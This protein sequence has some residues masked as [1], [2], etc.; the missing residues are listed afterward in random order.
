LGIDESK[1]E[2]RSGGHLPENV[3]YINDQDGETLTTF[4]G[5]VKEFSYRPAAKY[6]QL[7]CPGLQSGPRPK[8]E[9]LSPAVFKSYGDVGREHEK[10]LLDNFAIALMDKQNSKGYVIAYA[11]KRAHDGEARGRAERAKDYLIKMRGLDGER[12]FATD[13]GYREEAVVELYI[14]QNGGCAPPTLPTVD[15]RDVQIT[16][17][18]K[19]K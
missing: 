15:P 1:Y 11:G 10:L 5:Q 18:R 6:A 2:K 17:P 8:C 7:L 13:G 14:V 16:P 9:G 4:Q 12:L 19:L 3:Y